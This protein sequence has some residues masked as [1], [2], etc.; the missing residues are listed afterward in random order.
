MPGPESLWSVAQ[1]TTMY[2]RQPSGDAT[3]CLMDTLVGLRSRRLRI[4]VGVVGLAAM[5]AGGIAAPPPAKVPPRGVDPEESVVF[6]GREI[7]IPVV[8]LQGK[9]TTDHLRHLD[10]FAMDTHE[11]SVERYSRFVAASG[12]KTN[13]EVAG[14]GFVVEGDAGSDRGGA[15]W[16]LPLGQ[17]LVDSVR[18]RLPVVLVTPVD[19]MRFAQWAGKRL[20]TDLEWRIAALESSRERVLLSVFCV[21]LSRI[22]LAYPNSLPCSGARVPRSNLS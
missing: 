11:V 6:P 7:P 14:R 5:V 22:N 8:S 19:A 18:S 10:S 3:V 4:L 9:W 15:T 13:A 2:V 12:Y 21:L 1:R 16:R 17:N 20:P